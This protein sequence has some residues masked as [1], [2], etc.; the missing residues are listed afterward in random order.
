MVNFLYQHNK[1]DGAQICINDKQPVSMPLESPAMSNSLEPA[2]FHMSMLFDMMVVW[3]VG[4]LSQHW[5]HDVFTNIL[6]LHALIASNS[7][8]ACSDVIAYSSQFMLL[9]H[10]LSPVLVVTSLC[11]ACCLWCCETCYRLCCQKCL[12]MSSWDIGTK[13]SQRCRQAEGPKG[14]PLIGGMECWQCI[15]GAPERRW[16]AR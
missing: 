4:V 5:C 3:V 7:V 12:R 16:G 15:G 10:L 9:L 14:C 6:S 11:C 13:G 8:F 1:T 2:E